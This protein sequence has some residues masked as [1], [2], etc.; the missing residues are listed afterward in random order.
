L[1]EEEVFEVREVQIDLNPSDMPGPPCETVFC[2][3]CGENVSD[4]RHVMRDGKPLCR[5]CAGEAYYRSL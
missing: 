2:S 4:S 5:A 3:A 1:P